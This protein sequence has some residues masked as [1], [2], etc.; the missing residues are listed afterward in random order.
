M[1]KDETLFNKIQIE[2]GS[3]VSNIKRFARRKFSSRHSP[4]T[5]S[6]TITSHFFPI[7]SLK[8][9]LPLFF[10]SGVSLT[11]LGSASVSLFV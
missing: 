8:A 7:L 6:F 4:F 9:A 5:L 1:K 11:S 10:D 2:E 3:K